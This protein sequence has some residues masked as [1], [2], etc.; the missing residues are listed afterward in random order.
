MKHKPCVGCSNIF[1]ADLLVLATVDDLL[2]HWCEDCLHL[3]EDAF[4]RVVLNDQ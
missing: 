4:C 2:G 1:D 3:A